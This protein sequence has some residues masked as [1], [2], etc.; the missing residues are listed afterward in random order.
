MNADAVIVGG[1]FGGVAAALAACDKGLRVFLTEETDWLGGQVTS[2]GVPPDEHQWIE[3]F[4]STKRYRDYRNNVRETY[5]RTMNVKNEEACFNPGN[6]LVS[7]ICHDPRVTLHVLNEMLLPYVLTNQ[8]KI[9]LNTRITSVKKTEG[10]IHEMTFENMQTGNQYQ[11]IA[12]FYIDATEAGDVLPLAGLEYVTGAEAKSETGESHAPDTAN[13]N[14]IQAFTYVLGMEYRAGEDHT[15]PEPE[16]YQYWKEFHPTI[17][18]DK[19][20]SFYAPHPITKEKR[21]YTLFREETGFPLWEYR[22]IFD[23]N[24]FETPYH[25]GDITLMNW[26]QNDYFLGNIYDVAIVEKEKNE[27]QAKQLSLSLLYWLQTEAPRPDGG[28]GYP[29]L[30]LRKDIFG[31]EDGFAKAP[32]IRESRRIKAEYT[33]VEHDVSPDFNE[34]ETGKKYYDR[35]GIGSYSIDLHPSMAGRNYVDI[36][37]LPF[38]IP[39]GALIPKDAGNLL[40]GCKNI[41]TTHITNGCYRL[42]PTEWNI[43]EACGALIAFCLKNNT[44]PN[45][46]R[47]DEKLLAQ[48]QDELREDGFE[49]E[50]PEEFYK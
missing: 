6:G 45:A 9:E 10:T 24:Q 23:K 16:M 13:P 49:L 8:L 41:G 27:Y 35:V 1:G 3:E 33:I 40:A 43:G 32:Y 47:N 19:F 31:T 4:G 15:I 28:K 5:L 25:A 7:N 26:P 48:F 38:Y 2:Q 30:K 11:V 21:K 34:G 17:W 22:R 50:W 37:A 39:L 42:H 18:P 46:V 12:P 14:D 29:G 44:Q 20:L 36:P